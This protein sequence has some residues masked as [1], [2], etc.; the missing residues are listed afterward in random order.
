MVLVP[1]PL[2]M[3]DPVG[4]VQIYEVAPVTLEQEYDW[5]DPAHTP[6]TGPVIRDGV[7]N[8]FTNLIKRAELVPAQFEAVTVRFPETNAGLISSS[9]L[10]VPCPVTMVVLA[11]ANQL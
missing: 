6:V 2:F 4:R 9:I 3:T 10:V 5:V 11:G 8:P 7:A 1:W